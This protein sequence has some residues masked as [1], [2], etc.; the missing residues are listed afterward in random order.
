MMNPKTP[1]RGVIFDYG[2]TLIWLGP[3]RRSTRTDYADVVARPGA[4]RLARFLVSTGILGDESAAGD[5]V[6]RYLEIRERNRALA[7]E[8]GREITARESLISALESPAAVAPSSEARLRKAVSESFVPE[9]EAVEALPGAT[10]RGRAAMDCRV[11]SRAA[12]APDSPLGLN[13][14]AIVCIDTQPSPRLDFRLL[15]RSPDLPPHIPRS[16]F[17]A[18]A[19][20]ELRDRRYRGAFRRGRGGP[21]RGS[22]HLHDRGPAGR[23]R[24]REPRARARGGAQLRLRIPDAE[25]HDQSGPGARAEGRGA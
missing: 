15:G 24:P 18:R 1:L 23:R 5:F 3:E 9:I 4:E 20:L 8:T 7:E 21:R 16:E 17:H 6:N 12:G 14:L 10:G 22:P 13:H 25:D 19:R 2:N 11:A